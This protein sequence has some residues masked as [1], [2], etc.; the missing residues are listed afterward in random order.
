MITSIKY[1]MDNLSVISCESN[2]PMGERR[3][4]KS[5]KKNKEIITSKADNRDT[6]VIM[7]TSHYLELASKHLGDKDTYHRIKQD[8]TQQIG[9]RFNQ[10]LDSCL[11]K[12]VITEKDYHKLR[13]PQNVE[14]QCIYFFTKNSQRPRRS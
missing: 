5:L 8:P 14:T 10:F 6:T 1:D 13:L 4:L 3:A 2:L 7:A 9:R 11:Y 12:G